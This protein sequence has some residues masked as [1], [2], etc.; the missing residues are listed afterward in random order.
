MSGNIRANKRGDGSSIGRFNLHLTTL[1]QVWLL[2]SRMRKLYILKWN[3]PYCTRF[4]GIGGRICTLV[5]TPKICSFCC[6]TT[7]R[8]AKYTMRRRMRN[9]I[10]ILLILLS[11]YQSKI[12]NACEATICPVLGGKTRLSHMHSKLSSRIVE[13]EIL[14]RQFWF[15]LGRLKFS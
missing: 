10:F 3:L 12:M 15:F 1:Q 6:R 14:I 4:F 5:D 2:H 8:Q 13:L 11:S 9:S 7:G